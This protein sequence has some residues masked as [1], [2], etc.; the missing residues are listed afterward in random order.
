MEG[1]RKEPRASTEV[2]LP[3]MSNRSIRFWVLGLTLV[4]LGIAFLLFQTSGPP[5]PPP[6]DSTRN[7]EVNPRG[8]DD[9]RPPLVVDAFEVNSVVARNRIEVSGVLEPRRQVVVG[10]EVPGR[11]IEVDVE[12]HTPV[13]TGQPLVRLDPALPRAAVERAKASLVRAKSSERLAA[14]EVARQRELA[15]RGVASAAEL[16]RAESQDRSAAAQ[17]EEAQ[18]ALLDADPSD[19]LELLRC[20]IFYFVSPRTRSSRSQ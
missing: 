15:S 3:A 4:A 8:S 5:T 7:Q 12:E 18:A 6:T 17:V 13:K 19:E 2:T 10:A 20:R 9:S 16:D 11:V 14:S 1:Q